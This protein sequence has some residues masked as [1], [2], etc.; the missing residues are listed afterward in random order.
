MKTMDVVSTNDVNTQNEDDDSD[1]NQLLGGGGENLSEVD[2]DDERLLESKGASI[3]DE[4]SSSGESAEYPLQDNEPVFEPTQVSAENNNEN[5]AESQQS[6]EDQEVTSQNSMKATGKPA[7]LPSFAHTFVIPADVKKQFATTVRSANLS[8]KSSVAI[9]NTTIHPPGTNIEMQNVMRGRLPSTTGS[10]SDIPPDAESCMMSRMGQAQMTQQ[11]AVMQPTLDEAST[12]P[13][14]Q[15]N[16][17]QQHQQMPSVQQGH[18]LTTKDPNIMSKFSYSGPK[19]K[20]VNEPAATFPS[21]SAA[22]VTPTQT[23]SVTA[24]ANDEEDEGRDIEGDPFFSGVHYF[25]IKGV[26]SS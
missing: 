7:P 10:E 22:T 13:K 25:G 21:S 8:Q 2:D 12:Q 17:L 1:D 24:P 16:V 23:S 6:P 3:V 15:E 18:V 14:N 20:P 5:A 4:N 26:I 9:M 11:H 19:W